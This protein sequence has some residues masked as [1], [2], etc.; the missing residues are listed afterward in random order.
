MEPKLT[1]REEALSVASEAGERERDREPAKIFSSEISGLF[2]GFRCP[3]ES[4]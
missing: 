4:V 2:P 1:P 3:K